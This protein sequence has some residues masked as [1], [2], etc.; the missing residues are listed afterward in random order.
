MCRI[1][2]VFVYTKATMD[3]FCGKCGKEKRLDWSIHFSRAAGYK[4]VSRLVLKLDTITK[5]ESS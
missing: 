5:T 3:E 1:L 4:M 2:F